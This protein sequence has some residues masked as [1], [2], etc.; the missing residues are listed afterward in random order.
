MT[1]YKDPWD[2]T[3]DEIMLR[4]Q[5]IA[6]KTRSTKMACDDSLRMGGAD[7]LLILETVL[8][9]YLILM[10]NINLSQQQTQLSNY[11]K[12]SFLF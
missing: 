4:Y 6:K 11:V 7:Q 12:S 9:T 3:I 1:N 10:K 8:I 2:N 5:E